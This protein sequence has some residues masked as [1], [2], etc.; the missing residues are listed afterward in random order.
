M[1]IIKD[2]YLSVVSFE[3]GESV[4]FLASS[5]DVLTCPTE[6]VE[7]WRDGLSGPLD[8]TLRHLGHVPADLSCRTLA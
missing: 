2:G 4:I 3:G 6:A 7:K 1:V 8:A 5:G